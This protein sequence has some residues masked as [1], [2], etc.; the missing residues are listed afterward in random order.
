M[1]FTRTLM[2]F[3]AAVA[4][5]APAA[6]TAAELRVGFSADAHFAGPGKPPEPRNRND[7]P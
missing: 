1:K 6:L 2:A 5:A 7:H 4:I 3:G